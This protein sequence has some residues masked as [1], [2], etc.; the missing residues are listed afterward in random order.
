MLHNFYMRKKNKINVCRKSSLGC[1]SS[2]MSRDLSDIIHSI[3]SNLIACAI[4]PKLR[5]LTVVPQDIESCSFFYHN[6]DK[7]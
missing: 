1:S 5:I 7:N 3:L 2:P 4:I 6:Y